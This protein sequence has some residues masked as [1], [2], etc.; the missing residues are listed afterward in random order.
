M[1]NVIEPRP[2]GSAGLRTCLCRKSSDASR[3]ISMKLF[4]VLLLSLAV[5][6]FA[7]AQQNLPAHKIHANDLVGVSVYG[8][9]ELTRT[10][11]VGADGTI[12]LPMLRD[13]IKADE[14]MPEE[15]EQAIVR[16]LKTQEILVDPFVTVPV[17]EYHSL[18]PI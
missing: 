17:A 2:S 11:R 13:K 8:E 3:R 5:A 1:V 12:R 10:V 6:A 16:A 18:Q 7:Q 15:L 9:P 14:L 4:I